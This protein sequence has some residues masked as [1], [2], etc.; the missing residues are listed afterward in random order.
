MTARA[1]A[2]LSALLL[3]ACGGGGGGS[4]ICAYISGGG[5]SVT[6]TVDPACSGCSVSNERAAADGDLGTGA[7]VTISPVIGA[8]DGVSI[9]ATAQHGVV[10]PAGAEPVIH[11]SK[12]NG[13]LCRGMST[14]LDGAV[15]DSSPAFCFQ[16]ANASGYDSMVASLPFDAVQIDLTSTEALENAVIDI[17]EICADQ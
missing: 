15:Q 11:F 9:R 12:A 6:S 1:V 10:F 2:P 14:Y 4:A 3:A 7:T 17:D 16:E 13:R 8:S 5:S